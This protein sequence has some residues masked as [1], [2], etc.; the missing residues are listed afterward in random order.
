MGKAKNLM[1]R[2]KDKAVKIH[3]NSVSRPIKDTGFSHPRA[4]PPSRT[5]GAERADVATTSTTSSPPPRPPPVRAP[6]RPS[7][8]ARAGSTGTAQIDWSALTTEDKRVFFEWLDEFFERRFGSSSSE[9]KAG[10]QV[11]S[12]RTHSLALSRG[13]SF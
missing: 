13:Q 10:S 1:E 8:M 4:P 5:G 7:Q 11:V 2:T 3:D 12:T 6:M 9:S